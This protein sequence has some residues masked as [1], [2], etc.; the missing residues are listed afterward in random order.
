MIYDCAL[1]IASLDLIYCMYI[2]FDKF[3]FLA[4]ALDSCK[5]WSKERCL[6]LLKIF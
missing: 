4:R 5:R 2:L 3:S 1:Q 6:M